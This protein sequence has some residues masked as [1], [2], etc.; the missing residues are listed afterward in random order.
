M[1]KATS[2][3]KTVVAYINGKLYQKEFETL[4][5][6]TQVYEALL[7]ADEATDAEALI[8]LFKASKTQA[9]IQLEL[10]FKAK[11]EESKKMQDILD[12][13]K[14]VKADGHVIFEVIENSLYVKGIRISTPELLIREIIKAE[15]EH[16]NDRVSALLNF[17]KLC[18]L[19]PDPRARFDLFRFIQN[20]KL[21]I[22][23]SGNFLT[24]RR[25]HSKKINNSELEKFI[26]QEYLKIKRWKKAPSNYIVYDSEDG[27]KS[28]SYGSVDREDN[29]TEEIGNLKD[30]Y[31]NLNTVVGNVY[32]DNHTRTFN[33]QIG[34]PMKIDRGNVDPDP[35]VECSRGAHTGSPEYVNNN[36]WLG[37]TVLACLIN[38]R[39]V[40]AV[41]K[42]D[43]LKMRSCEILPIAVAELDNKG[44]IIEPE[45][46]VFDLELAQNTQEELEAISK[47]NSTELEEY[48]KHEFIAQ[49]VDF[50]MLNNILES[51]TIS[52]NDA[53]KAIKN[54]TIKL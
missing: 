49:E 22:T 48:K 38:P 41:P 8:N 21:T 52:V 7:N 20:H 3:Q 42:H 35:E 24:Y 53:N 40:T 45:Y 34:V 5:E 6:K 54:R 14:K 44:N 37:N 10:E 50:T 36:A 30:L 19:N 26:T 46:E 31:D 18:A 2:I 27:Y 15:A 25:V 9:E 23:S 4:E 28:I 47:L 51:V 16:N 39:N 32:T 29:I 12:F 43:S 13:M 11:K 17:W 33:I 1:I